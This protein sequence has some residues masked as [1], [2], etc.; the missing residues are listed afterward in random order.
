MRQLDLGVTPRDISTEA[1]LRTIASAPIVGS[2]LRFGRVLSQPVQETTDHPPASSALLQ[3]QCRRAP[4]EYKPGATGQPA[5]EM[6]NIW[7][8]ILQILFTTKFCPV[9]SRTVLT[10]SLA[11]WRSRPIGSLTHRCNRLTVTT[12]SGLEVSTNQ[13]PQQSDHRSSASSTASQ[14][15]V[16]CL[17][18]LRWITIGSTAVA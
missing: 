16:T 6:P 5:S 17:A 18:G 14:G 9:P 11:L 2:T 8:S 10:R 15:S 13:I 3:A 4:C 7:M 1:L 12:I